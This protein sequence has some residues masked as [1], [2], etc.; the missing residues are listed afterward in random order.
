MAGVDEFK[1]KIVAL[2]I[3]VFEGVIEERREHYKTHP[4]PQANAGTFMMRSTPV[5][6]RAASA[7]PNLD[8]LRQ[9]QIDDHGLPCGLDC[10]DAGEGERPCIAGGPKWR[11]EPTSKNGAE[12]KSH[13]SRA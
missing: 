7:A 13:T 9:V 6:I 12:S 5:P 4:R 8:K 10:R 2:I 1:D 3:P 11:P